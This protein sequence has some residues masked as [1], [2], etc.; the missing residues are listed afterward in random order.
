M[1]NEHRP[2]IDSPS[3]LHLKDFYTPAAEVGRIIQE[4]WQN[5][6]LRKKIEEHFGDGIPTEVLNGPHGVM[7]RQICTPDR[8]FA[9]FLDLAKEANIE[10]L[11]FESVKD[12]FMA[13]NFTKL[14]FTNLPFMT[15][16][17]KDGK[18]IAQKEKII[19]FVHAGDNKLCDLKTLWGESLV[20]FH[21]WFLRTIFPITE[22]RI[23]DIYDWT[24]Q[25]GPSPREYYPALMAF[26]LAHYVLFDDYDLLAAEDE[27]T[28]E[29]VLPAFK[30]IEAEFGL[31]PL[32]VKLSKPGE[33]E[34]DPY[35]W[36]YDKEARDIMEKH[37]Q[38]RAWT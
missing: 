5:V 20:D 6:E 12:Q 22:N 21:H 4:R 26:A 7:W 14:A 38:E 8:E 24:K 23:V 35:W 29:A 27:F 18:T 32:V 13:E 2:R 28:M 11:C 37:K 1:G 3:E 31:R 34:T 25:H 9:R 16:L 17:T 30:E 33:Y 19:D 15:G 36:C 10:P